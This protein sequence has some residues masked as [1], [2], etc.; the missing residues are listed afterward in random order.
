[1]WVG[2]KFWYKTKWIPLSEVDLVSG[3]REF[4]E[5]E[6]REEEKAAAKGP[7]SFWRRAWEMS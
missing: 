1:M 5:D 3:R 2:Y 6:A 7:Q 4:D